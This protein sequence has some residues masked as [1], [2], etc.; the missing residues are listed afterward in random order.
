VDSWEFYTQLLGRF[1]VA[2]VAAFVIYYFLFRKHADFTIQLR[3]GEFN[4]RGRV[5]RIHQRAIAHFLLEELAL[6]ESVKI[7]GAWD[8][9][10]L[11]LWFRGR[12]GEGEKQRIRNFLLGRL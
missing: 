3:R 12:I 1:V 11:R 5:P 6:K 2:G 8:R 7:Q 4:C 9:K 10:R